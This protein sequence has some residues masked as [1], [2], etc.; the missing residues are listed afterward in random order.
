MGN[1]HP[2]S[3]AWS[4]FF[5]TTN[6]FYNNSTAD[7]GSDRKEIAQKLDDETDESSTSLSAVDTVTIKANPKL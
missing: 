1:F 3:A 2:S 5:N 6:K 7:D 4:K